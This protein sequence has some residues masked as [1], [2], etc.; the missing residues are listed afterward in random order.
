MTLEELFKVG[1]QYKEVVFK[2]GTILKNVKIIKNDGERLWRGM[3]GPKR[4]TFACPS[5]TYECRFYDDVIDYV[6]GQIRNWPCEKYK[7]E[8]DKILLF[9]KINEDDKWAP[10]K[11]YH[12]EDK[13]KE[14]KEVKDK[15]SLNRQ[16]RIDNLLWY[17][18]MSTEELIY[19]NLNSLT[20]SLEK[21]LESTSND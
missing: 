5:T 9:C 7:I 8:K 14:E 6:I 13:K 17:K 3:R 19:E 20:K 16:M 12:K 15:E 11:I 21:S 1:Q 10:L 2:D 18:K 4:I